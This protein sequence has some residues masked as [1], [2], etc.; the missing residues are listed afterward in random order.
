[1]EEVFE[2]NGLDGDDNRSGW[3][4]VGVELDELGVD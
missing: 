1:M 3:G 2:I 4:L